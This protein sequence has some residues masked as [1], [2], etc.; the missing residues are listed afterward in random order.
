MALLALNPGEAPVVE[1]LLV[2]DIAGLA[3]A[4]VR[5]WGPEGAGV[6]SASDE[7][8][9]RLDGHASA[10]WLIGGS[11]DQPAPARLSG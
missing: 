6:G 9:V 8:V 4:V 7:V 1:S 3:R 10:L 11:A 2:K 5:T